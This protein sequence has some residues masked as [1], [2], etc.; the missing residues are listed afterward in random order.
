[1]TINQLLKLDSN[2]RKRLHQNYEVYSILETVSS[3]LYAP[4]NFRTAPHQDH[5]IFKN[6]DRTAPGPIKTEKYRTNSHRAVRGPN[7]K[8]G[9]FLLTDKNEAYG[10]IHFCFETK[11]SKNILSNI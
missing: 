10:R 5:K 2:E 4:R 6:S 3:I 11:I 1:M 9:H 7:G 8:N